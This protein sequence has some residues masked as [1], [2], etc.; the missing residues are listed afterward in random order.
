MGKVQCVSLKS[1]IE[2]W[3]II[4]KSINNIDTP[5]DKK[6]Y[7]EYYRLKLELKSKNKPKKEN[8]ILQKQIFISF[9]KQMDRFIKWYYMSHP[10]QK[11]NISLKAKTSENLQIKKLKNEYI[12]PHENVPIS[13]PNRFYGYS[14]NN[15][16]NNNQLKKVRFN[17]DAVSKEKDDRNEKNLNYGN[18]NN[19]G[20]NI[21]ASKN[22]NIF[23]NVN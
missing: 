3:E 20:N 10:N 12:N 16:A 18:K 22:L 13:T 4:E 1:K 19:F 6:I 5:L 7:D 17:M 21:N 23:N 9:K 8:E 15:D 11:S 2:M 14:Y